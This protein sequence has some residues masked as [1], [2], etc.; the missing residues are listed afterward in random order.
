MGKFTNRNRNKNKN[1][2]KN[3][4][5]KK[6]KKK[7]VERIRSNSKVLAKRTNPKK[8]KLDIRYKKIPTHVHTKIQEFKNKIKHNNHHDVIKDLHST[9]KEHAKSGHIHKDQAFEHAKRLEEIHY[10]H[11]DLA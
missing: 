3:R 8:K 9:L 7:P 4:S 10:K 6:N 2:N 5:F 11:E 1:K